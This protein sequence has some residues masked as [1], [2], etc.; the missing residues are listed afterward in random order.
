MSLIQNLSTKKAL[1]NTFY[2]NSCFSQTVNFGQ[3][4]SHCAGVSAAVLI[5]FHSGQI[6]GGILQKNE[7]KELFNL[8]NTKSQEL[9]AIGYENSLN[10]D[11]VLVEGFIELMYIR[12]NFTADKRN[13][14]KVNNELS[15]TIET[16]L[17]M[18]FDEQGEVIPFNDYREEWDYKRFPE[19]FRHYMASRSNAVLYANY[20]YITI[21][22]MGEKFMVIDG[23]PKYGLY[24]YENIDTLLIDLVSFV[25]NSK[26]TLHHARIFGDNDFD[27]I[28][29]SLPGASNALQVTDFITLEDE[30]E[31]YERETFTSFH[32]DKLGELK[33]EAIALSED[34][35]KAETIKQDQ[36]IEEDNEEND[37]NSVDPDTIKVFDNA[38]EIRNFLKELCRDRL[39]NKEIELKLATDESDK[40][41]INGC[42]YYAD[43]IYR[44]A[45]AFCKLHI[46]IACSCAVLVDGRSC[47]TKGCKRKPKTFKLY[48]STCLKE[49]IN[50]KKKSGEK[51]ENNAD[52]EEKNSHENDDDGEEEEEE[53][54]K[55]P[56]WSEKKIKEIAM[57]IA[58]KFYKMILADPSL[59][60]YF[61]ITIRALNIRLG[62]HLQNGKNFD[63]AFMEIEVPHA[64][65]LADLE[66]YVVIIGFQI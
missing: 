17:A 34:Q 16:P 64:Q 43:P 19:V 1:K 30:E 24:W 2:E 44:G 8:I 51:I 7:L 59:M 35:K 31:D 23:V 57:K 39:E 66:Y 9:Y 63:L 27:V 25:G 14:L 21:L 6:E 32:D 22:T 45:G 20:H 48:C 49:R 58:K 3:E 18:K 11:V 42:P 10:E 53:D 38:A 50:A 28:L 15:I 36:V 29:E 52:N 47:E 26:F 56:Q 37:D 54:E 13:I 33:E 61:G 65:S 46:S 62:E 5:A 60:I 12:N 41:R 55:V 40:C 4:L